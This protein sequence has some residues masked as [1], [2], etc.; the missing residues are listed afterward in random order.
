MFVQNPVPVI[1]IIPEPLFSVSMC[2]K[3]LNSD[4]S[5]LTEVEC[6]KSNCEEYK[7]DLCS[8]YDSSVEDGQ[9]N[10]VHG[11]D[12]IE[13]TSSSS[14]KSRKNS[15]VYYQGKENVRCDIECS[16]ARAKA[17]EL[18]IEDLY[19]DGKMSALDADSYQKSNF[20]LPKELD[21]GESHEFPVTNDSTHAAS[22]K[23][24]SG[25]F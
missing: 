25:Y 14:S 18:H 5:N 21:G 10:V 8:K 22:G 13:G 4:C 17:K 7:I 12:L 11:N 6:K 20:I 2:G 3:Q 9:E 15:A 19:A 24:N 1:A 16:C 23:G